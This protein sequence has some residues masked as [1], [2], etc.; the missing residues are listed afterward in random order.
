MA[1]V[2]GVEPLGMTADALFIP[3]RDNSLLV[4]DGGTWQPLERAL[5]GSLDLAITGQHFLGYLDGQACWVLD[6]AEQSGSRVEGFIWQG[7]RSQLGLI[8]EQDFLLAG[9]ALQITH[10]Y[11]NHQFCGRCGRPMVTDLQERARICHACNLHFYPRLSP[12]V[13]VLV[14]RGD[15]CLLARHARAS[16]PV[17]SALAG[18]IEVGERPEDTVHRE[19]QEEVGLNIHQLRYFASQPWPFPGQLMLGF[20]AEYHSGEI[21]ADGI[22][23]LEADW[24]RYD[25]L[26]QTPPAAT[27]SGQ[28]IAHFLAQQQIRQEAYSPSTL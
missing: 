10:W 27:L 23:I 5:I 4:R 12:C 14:T 25:R 18:F 2:A 11:G 22:E 16:R 13:I 3:V 28:L 20:T 24:F 8:P 1:F 15:H 26:P 19:V 7:L 6:I 17:F 9:R 21:Q